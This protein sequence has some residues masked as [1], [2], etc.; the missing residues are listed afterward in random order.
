M[1]ANITRLGRIPFAG[2]N[3]WSAERHQAALDYVTEQ[4]SH[5][6]NPEVRGLVQGLVPISDEL[7]GGEQLLECHLRTGNSIATADTLT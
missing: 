2:A 7:G 1:L 4:A 3:R 6:V 5:L